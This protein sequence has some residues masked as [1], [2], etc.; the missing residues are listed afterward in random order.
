[1][2]KKDDLTLEQLLEQIE[3]EY[4]GAIAQKALEE[5]DDEYISHENVKKKMIY[6][7]EYN[8]RKNF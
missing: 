5:N 4:F 7:S 2:I 8:T 6:N 3:D 1:M